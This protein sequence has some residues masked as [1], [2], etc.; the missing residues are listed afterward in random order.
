MPGFHHPVAGAFGGDGETI[1]LAGKADCEIADIDHFL[2][3]A[4]A[5]GGNLACFQR[6]ETSEIGLEGAQL[7]AEQPDQFATA[8]RRYIAPYLEGGIGPVDHGG[9]TFD[10][11]GLEAR[12][13]FT[14]HRAEGG[15]IAAG[16]EIAGNAHPVEQG[17][18]FLFHVELRGRIHVKLSFLAQ[19]GGKAVFDTALS[20]PV[21]VLS[22]NSFV[23]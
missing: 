16:I 17:R 13:L 19:R 6:D 20:T 10:R 22:P 5:L 4:E 12:D 14:G 23:L 21:A 18:G 2:H 1:K 7:F 8:G 3:L 11:N 9:D 15:H